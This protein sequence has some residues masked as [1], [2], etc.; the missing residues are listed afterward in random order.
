MNGDGGDVDPL[1]RLGGILL[2]VF[3]SCITFV[4]G[5]CSLFTLWLTV[6]WRE[7]GLTYL[8]ISLIILAV[9]ILAVRQGIRLLSDDA[10][11]DD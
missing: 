1:A 2:I 9:G 4:G 10:R 3:G 5:G 7:A 8:V 11:N 6:Y